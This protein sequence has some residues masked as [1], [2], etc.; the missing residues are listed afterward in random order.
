MYEAFIAAFI[1]LFVIVDPIGIA[2]VF[3]GLTQGAD[4]SHKR[5][6]AVKGTIVGT[7]ILVF[8]ALVGK[9]F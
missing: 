5:T 1:G 4:T 3:A 2:P 6:M 8:F 9:P 7:L